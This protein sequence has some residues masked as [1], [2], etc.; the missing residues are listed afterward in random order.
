MGISTTLGPSQPEPRP[1]ILTMKMSQGQP[2][3][4]PP[5]ELGRTYESEMKKVRGELAVNE[6]TKSAE[7]GKRSIGEA[8]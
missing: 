4:P 7:F 8:S 5:P 2:T 1:S 3:W 6:G